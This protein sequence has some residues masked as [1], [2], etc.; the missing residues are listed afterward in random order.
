MQYKS[1]TP[2]KFNKE[3]MLGSKKISHKGTK[4]TKKELNFSTKLCVLGVFVGK[5]YC[6]LKLNGTV[7]SD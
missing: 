1:A 2:M 5:N 3:K 6:C 4:S 7:T